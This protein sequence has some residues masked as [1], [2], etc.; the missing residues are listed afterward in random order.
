MIAI[1]SMWV[2]HPAL[3]FGG[4]KDS[5]M[6]REGASTVCSI[7]WSRRR[8]ASVAD[9]GG[10]EFTSSMSSSNRRGH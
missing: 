7:P 6:G 3:P 10:E 4:V 9:R 8:S 1:N 5:G 2:A